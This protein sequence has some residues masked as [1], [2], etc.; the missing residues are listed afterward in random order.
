MQAIVKN[1]T[2]MASAAQVAC[3]GVFAHILIYSHKGCQCD[4]WY[5]LFLFYNFSYF[6]FC[7]LLSIFAFILCFFLLSLLFFF[8]SLL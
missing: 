6:F 5:I 2:V 3:L 1:P 8:T 7:K 4:I